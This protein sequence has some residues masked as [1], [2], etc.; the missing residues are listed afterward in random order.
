MEYLISSMGQAIRRNYIPRVAASSAAAAVTT[1]GGPVGA[2]EECRGE[3]SVRHVQAGGE[4]GRRDE[5]E[6]ILQ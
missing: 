4:E 2:M 6:H 5:E 3:A 1:R